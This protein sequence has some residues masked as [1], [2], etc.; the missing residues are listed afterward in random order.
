MPSEKKTTKNP[1][2]AAIA[3]TGNGFKGRALLEW[4]ESHPAFPKVLYLSDKTP[5]ITLKKT[6]Y[7]RIDLTE[8]LADVK[9]AEI[10]KKE[11]IETLVHTA[12]PITPPHNL[13]KAHELVSVGSMY[14]VNAAAEAKVKKLI[15]AST[16]DVYGAFAN[17]P[18]YLTEEHPARG[19]LKSRFLKDK[20]DAE[21]RFL[22]Y[23]KKNPGACVTILRPATIL[24]PSI[25]SYKTQYLK[26]WVVPTV[27]GY[28]P[29]VQFIHEEDLL[30][31]FKKVILEDHPG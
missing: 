25:Q 12:L 21:N 29:L 15:L 14:L 22:N 1:K 6:H 9:I 3:L 10:L 27:W 4:L 7:W 5:H 19:G 16:A 30:T 11:K 23:A 17:N 8:T 13:A 26:R 24:G 2:Q 20:I 18:N 28:D 31:A